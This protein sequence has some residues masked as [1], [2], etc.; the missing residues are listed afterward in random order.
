[1]FSLLYIEDNPIDA[2]VVLR[3]VNDIHEFDRLHVETNLANGLLRM[4][5]ETYDL[6]FLDL[7]L[8]DTFGLDS[9][10]K[11][12]KDFP[13]IPI[14]VFTGSSDEKVAVRA[15]NMGAQD[16]L[17]KGSTSSKLLKKSVF[18]AIERHKNEEEI[19]RAQDHLSKA[20]KVAKI[21][22]WEFDLITDEANISDGMIKILGLEKDHGI[23]SLEHYLERIISSDRKKVKKIL[24]SLSENLDSVNYSERIVTPSGEIR[25]LYTTAECR[26][27]K[28]GRLQ[29]VFG[30]SID[31]TDNKDA[32]LKLK[33][34]E[35]KL[36]EAQELS[37]LGNWEYNFKT[38]KFSGSPQAYEV[39][40][41]DND[42]NALK[43]IQ[44]MSWGSESIRIYNTIRTHLESKEPFTIEFKI[45]TRT[46]AIK[47]LKATAKIFSDE[48]KDERIMRGTVQ[49]ITALKE[50]SIVKEQFANR[51]EIEVNERT[52]EL[53]ETH[54][55][56]A[57]SLKKEKELGE[58]KSRF[59]STA[60]H[61]FRTPLTVIQSSIGFLEMQSAEFD[62]EI[63][64]EVSKT[65]ARVKKE[66][67]RMSQMMDDIL[68]LHK[69]EATTINVVNESLGLT[70]FLTEILDSYNQIQTDGREVEL[71]VIESEYD[72]VTD[73]NLLQQI[74]SNL[75]SNALKYSVNKPAPHLIVRFKK[76]EV[77]IEIKDFGM[78]IPA[79]EQAL[80][81]D[82]FYRASN[83]TGISG[84]GLG[85]SIV[86]E[87]L[88][89][90]GGS[91]EIKS[92]LKKG[93]SFLITL[94]K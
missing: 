12:K 57:L 58:L 56:L 63:K 61:Q 72:I 42:S 7:S 80:I 36:L 34:S 76:K 4:A 10:E 25:F 23:S 88:D 67:K 40:D 26:F 9:I 17:V 59:V 29:S 18:Y 16:Y 30:A 52:Q 31:V 39:F 62:D 83:V 28:R 53:R 50:A 27:T 70:K 2:K 49:D 82:P 37:N 74:V 86:K 32:E 84:T 35:E 60:S 78:G 75:L 13:S 73:K 77:V 44:E 41:I 48:H 68:I 20:E 54:E 47:H 87:Y 81:F 24:N 6:V 33:E 3:Q 38:E 92:K 46:G 14:I 55:K 66:V 5:N 19:K 71:K 15:I 91:I 22:S 8:P 69:I 65:T 1:M 79:K 21:G 51:L 93:T 85:T 90:L 64:R 94:N 43:T 11:I 45:G 89:L